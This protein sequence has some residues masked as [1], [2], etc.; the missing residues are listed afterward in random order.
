[1]DEQEIFTGERAVPNAPNMDPRIMQEH[2]VRYERALPLVCGKRVLDVACGAGYGT[3]L[4]AKNA[5]HVVGGDID[6]GA[7]RYSSRH[8][9]ALNAAFAVLDARKL[10]FADRSFD[11][12][13]SFETVEHLHE[14]EQ[15]L[16]EIVRVLAEDGVAI[17]S[18]PLGGPAGNPFHLS[19]YQ[20]PHFAAFLEHFFDNVEISY[21]RGASFSDVPLSPNSCPTFTGEYAFAVCSGLKR[22]ASGLTS[23]II[24]THNNLE[25][26]RRC[27]ESIERHTPEPHELIIVDNGSTDGTPGFLRSYA[28]ARENVRVILNAENRG[29]AAGN[30]LGFALS[31]GEFVLLLNNDTLVTPGW[32]GRML[33]VLYRHP[34]AGLVG[35]RSN[36]VSGPQLVQGASYRGEDELERFAARWARDHEGESE[37]VSRLVGFCLLLRRSVL[38]RVGGLDERFGTGNFED[39]DFCLR[40]RAT[41]F[42]LRIAQ[43][44][45]V[46]HEG[47][48]TF[49]SAGIDYRAAME[50]NFQLFKAKWGLPGEL[51]MGE[52]FSIQLPA[53][54]VSRFYVPLPELRFTHVA[55]DGGRIWEARELRAQARRKELALAAEEAL[56]REDWPQ[57]AQALR[58]L[59][60]LPV[61]APAERAELWNRLG[62]CRYRQADLHGARE[63][64]EQALRADPRSIDALHNLAQLHMELGELDRA[65]QYLKRA[66]ALDPN[67]AGILLSLAQC[68]AQLGA[69]DAA[70]VALR[71]VQSLQPTLEGVA[72][73]IAELEAAT[74]APE[75]A[76]QPRKGGMP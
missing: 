65:S 45:F 13:V 7:V 36:Y 41:G 71:R 52:G 49:R 21:Q 12:V 69:T 43:D 73:A 75:S 25:L 63:A 2:W 30:N 39:D 54:V 50:R 29:F 16:A 74:L 46:H 22:P 59:L 31:R 57:A 24:L 76:G 17:L 20:R 40:A 60:D 4:L 15:F 34:D 64:F 18:V 26:T 8:Y 10:P 6:F 56:A 48:R 1:M 28:A 42:R 23:I 9:N 70:L 68:A 67:D 37:E 66:I 32:L 55:Q 27:L 58:E 47:S 35:P 3:K 51:K 38:Q 44:C 14:P 33:S 5:R 11:A 62:A 19:Y 72:E 61:A 53:D